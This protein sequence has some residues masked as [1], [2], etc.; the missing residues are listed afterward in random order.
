VTVVTLRTRLPYV[1]TMLTQ[2]TGRPILNGARIRELLDQGGF[3]AI[4]FNNVS[5]IGGPGV[6]SYA[7]HAAKLYLAHEHWLVCPTHVLW[8]H[9]RERCDGRECLRCQLRH[10]RPPQLWRYTGLLERQIAEVDTFV[11]M[12]EFSRAKHREF[13]FPREME[14]LPCFLP[15]P[16]SGPERHDAN[17]ASPHPRPYFLYVGRLETIKGVDDLVRASARYRD[18][19]LL[20]IGDGTREGA[21]RDLA[22][23]NPRVHFLGRLPWDRLGPYYRHAI[24]LIAPSTCFE[25]FG[26]ILIEA[27]SH[28]T[29]VIAR[30]LGPFPE[31]VS[32]SGGGALFDT[33][34]DLL[35][36]MGT[37]QRD[38]EQR[39]RMGIA[40]FNG[41]RA[42]WCESVV[43]PRYLEMVDRA[44][45]AHAQ[46]VH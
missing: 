15:D 44:Q 35:G 2:Q 31:I 37:L 40:G 32:Q 18:A 21:L 30:R 6:L 20:V 24:A 41:Y 42:R 38:P 9:G 33:P 29:P 39:R 22:R 34:D 27:F 12:S 26:L 36:A 19:D 43:I 17:V 25:T 28:S 45:Q 14:V 7:R 3:D 11:A 13:G 46:A 5:L 23:D 8:R 10:H 4:T 16:D 1:S